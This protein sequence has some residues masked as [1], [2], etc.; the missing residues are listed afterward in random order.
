MP[1]NNIIDLDSKIIKD[2]IAENWLQYSN[3]I[4]F[5]CN[6]MWSGWDF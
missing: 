4:T 2:A 3:A 5:F 6:V 1:E